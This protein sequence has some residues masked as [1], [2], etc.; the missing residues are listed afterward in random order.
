MSPHIA[1]RRDYPPFVSSV[2]WPK[3]VIGPLVGCDTSPDA[4]VP[5]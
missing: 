4:D 5:F 3:P 1:K 2:L